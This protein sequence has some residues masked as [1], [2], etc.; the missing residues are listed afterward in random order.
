MSMYISKVMVAASLFLFLR[1]C[2]R[3]LYPFAKEPSSFCLIQFTNTDA[4]KSILNKAIFY[5]YDTYLNA[6]FTTSRYFRRMALV[7]ILVTVTG[8]CFSVSIP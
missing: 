4:I 6:R 7:V 2:N 8:N 1:Y 5:S 3:I